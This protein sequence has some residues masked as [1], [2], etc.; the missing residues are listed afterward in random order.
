MGIGCGC[1]Q[2]VQR[3]LAD[4]SDAAEA[5]TRPIPSPELAAGGASTSHSPLVEPMS[6]APSSAIHSTSHVGPSSTTPTS[7]TGSPKRVLG[8]T[9]TPTTSRA[10][11]NVVVYAH[12]PQPSARYKNHPRKLLEDHIALGRRLSLQQHPSL[13]GGAIVGSY[14]Q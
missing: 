6:L 2:V 12:Y 4:A 5:S 10:A 11:I 9:S 13:D 8:C 1:G 14:R 7:S 3:P